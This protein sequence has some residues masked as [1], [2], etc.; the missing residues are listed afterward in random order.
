MKTLPYEIEC[1][2]DFMAEKD[3]VLVKLENE[4]T[5]QILGRVCY[6]EVSFLREGHTF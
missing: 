6:W 4:A 2:L 3:K 1:K 5:I